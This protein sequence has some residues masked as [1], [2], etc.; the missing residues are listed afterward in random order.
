MCRNARIP[1]RKTLE[2]YLGD[3]VHNIPE[4]QPCENANS[5]DHPEVP[6]M[7]AY[8]E[9]DLA[10]WGLVPEW[11][12]PG[13]FD[14]AKTMMDATRNAKAET[15][16]EKASFAQSIRERRCLLFLEGFYE[17]QHVPKA[18]GKGKETKRHYVSMKDGNI[19]TCGGVWSEWRDERLGK[20]LSTCSMITTAANPL[21]AGIHN[22][23]ERQPLIL[24]RDAWEHWLKPGLTDAEIESLMRVF[25]DDDMQAVLSPDGPSPAPPDGDG[26][27]AL[28]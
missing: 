13:D 15:I 12:R 18:S 2:E 17:W 8:G 9:V 5:F 24:P 14:R 25:P 21:M 22:S 20:T 1:A 23:G 19:F 11:V 28:F 3:L 16:F 7:P 6:I 26:Q 27:G 10:I 4:Y